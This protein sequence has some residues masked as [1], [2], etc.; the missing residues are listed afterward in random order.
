[1]ESGMEH[2]EKDLEK[3]DR[4]LLFPEEGSADI[5]EDFLNS[6]ALKKTLKKVLVL[7]GA[8]ISWEEKKDCR[9]RRISKE[10]QEALE[11]LYRTYEFSDHFQVISERLQCANLMN[12][13][14]T[15]LITMDDFFEA[16]L[17]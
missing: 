3:F 10:E 5:V 7:S 15:G 16:L 13:V 12:Y 8:D 17:H 4:I 11:Q 6:G 9:F 2:L 14:K 1:M